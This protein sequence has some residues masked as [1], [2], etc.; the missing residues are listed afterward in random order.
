[1]GSKVAIPGLKKALFDRKPAVVLAAAHALQVLDNPAG[2]Q[3]YYEVL[4]GERKSAEGLVAQHMETLKD[5]KKMAALGFEEGIQ[6]IPF[7]DISFSAAKAPLGFCDAPCSRHSLLDPASA[8]GYGDNGLLL[9]STGRMQVP[10]RLLVKRNIR[11]S[12]FPAAPARSLWP[13]FKM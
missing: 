11:Y 8:E 3:A 9:V 5:G 12:V 13:Q 10:P 1:M 4:T 2:Y 6:F 7:A